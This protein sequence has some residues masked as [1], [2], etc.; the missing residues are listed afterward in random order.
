MKGKPF[1][2]T[3]FRKQSLTSLSIC[4][5]HWILMAQ[6]TWWLFAYRSQYIFSF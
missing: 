3:T 5:E 6:S 1:R 2:A 4:K